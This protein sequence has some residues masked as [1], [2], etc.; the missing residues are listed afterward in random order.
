[1]RSNGNAFR[2]AVF[3]SHSSSGEHAVETPR[4][5][6]DA[7]QV[8]NVRVPAEILEISPLRFI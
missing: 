1:M 7:M 2:D 6:R 8:S 4:D 3:R 5:T